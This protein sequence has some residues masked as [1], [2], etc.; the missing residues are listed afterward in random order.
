MN[1]TRINIPLS[2]LTQVITLLTANLFPVDTM[3]VQFDS[4]NTANAI[5]PNPPDQNLSLLRYTA[6][7]HNLAG[8]VQTINNLTNV[9]LSAMQCHSSLMIM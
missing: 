1:I 8:A 5:S 4:S 9:R 6:V 7:L 2:K 3:P